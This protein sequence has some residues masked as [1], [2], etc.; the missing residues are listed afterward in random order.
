MSLPA[1]QAAPSR[2]RRVVRWLAWASVILSFPVWTAAFVVAP[3]VPLEPARRAA[4]AGVLLALG[5][6]MFWGAGLVLGAEVMARFR[7]PKVTTGKSFAGKRVV[8]IGAT[9]GLGEAVARAVRREA[10]ELVLV[11]RDAARVEALAQGLGARAL[12]AD[13]GD[14]GSLAA[15]AE[16]AGPV[17]HVVCATGQDVRKPFAAHSDEEL[18]REL[19]VDLLGPM[20]VARAFLPSLAEHGTVALFGGFGDG[21]IA[22]PYYAPDVAARAGLAAFCVSVNHELALEGRTQRLCYVCPAPADTPAERPYAALWQSLGTP[23]VEPEK[24]ADFVLAALAARRTE[25]VMGFG[26]RAFSRLHGALPGVSGWLLRRLF[27]RP[28]RAHLGQ[29]GT[30]SGL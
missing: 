23:L 21:R 25:A 6:V 22:F 15:A 14:A 27:G 26:T 5:E 30:P 13:L 16:A 11:A 18:Q 2:A 3:F 1:P 9:G 24:V 10:G 19:A 28:L 20:R 12:T 7:P 4:L 8:V 17:D 29:T